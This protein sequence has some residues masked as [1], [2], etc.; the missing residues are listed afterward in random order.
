MQ[1]SFED[2]IAQSGVTQCGISRKGKY[3][4]EGWWVWQKYRGYVGTPSCL[5]WVGEAL[6]LGGEDRPCKN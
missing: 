5:E 3:D 6:S 2:G 1:V 4:R